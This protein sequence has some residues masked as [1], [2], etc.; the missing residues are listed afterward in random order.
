ML[1]RKIYSK[2]VE[3][4]NT[5]QG[6]TALLI[7]GARR[8]GKSHICKEFGENEYKSYILIDFANVPKEIVELIENESYDLDIFF[9]K[10]S[11][12]YSVT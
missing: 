4:K 1:K 12:F 3:W 2:L 9:L 6:E 8:V 10:L 11:A 5:S 7:N